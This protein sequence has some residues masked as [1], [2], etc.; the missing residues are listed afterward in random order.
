MLIE[1]RTTWKVCRPLQ[2]IWY[3]MTGFVVLRHITHHELS[4]RVRASAA[5]AYLQE[6]SR[7]EDPTRDCLAYCVTRSSDRTFT[8]AEML[9]LHTSRIWTSMTSVTGITMKVIQMQCDR[10]LRPWSKRSEIAQTL[11]PTTGC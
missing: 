5:Q 7:S 11:S 3:A 2:A 1:H 8:E 4:R 10:T 6:R 9:G